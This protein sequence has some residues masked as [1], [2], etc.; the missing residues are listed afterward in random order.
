LEEFTREII[1]YG[2]LN[3]PI[4]SK[5]NLNGIKDLNG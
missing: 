1:T 3:P 4:T 5:N 2:L